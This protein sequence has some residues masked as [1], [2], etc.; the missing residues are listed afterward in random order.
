MATEKFCEKDCNPTKLFELI[1]AYFMPMQ[2]KY[3]WGANPYYYLAGKYRIH[4][5]YIQEMLQDTRYSDEDII[6]VIEHLRA[7]GGAEFSWEA[8]EAARYFYSDEQVGKWSAK[9]FLHEKEILVVG[10]GPSVRAHK[11]A[12]ES[13]IKNYQP[14][15]IALNTE[16]SLSENLICARAACHPVRLLADCQQ[17]IKLPQPLIT[18][19]SMLPKNV[20]DELSGKQV[21][22]FGLSVEKDKFIFS[23][24]SCTLPNALVFSYVLAIANSGRARQIN[25]VGF[26]GYPPDDSRNRDMEDLLRVYKGFG[27]VPLCSLTP[28]RYDVPMKSIYGL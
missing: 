27:S 8:L 1:R 7:E 14:Y 26:D 24:R 11:K 16:S 28:T 18:P 13:Y 25:L 12:I 21:F 4:P 20:Q 22:D 9:E 3:G 5:S 19:Y 10:S 6:A 23:E 17:Y 15:V 2:A